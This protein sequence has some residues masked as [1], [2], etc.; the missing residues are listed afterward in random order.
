M[1][2]E[3]LFAVRA[4]GMNVWMEG[5]DQPYLDLVMGYSSVNFGHCHP[6]IIAAV[7]EAACA[8][9][10]IHAFHTAPQLE[11][12]ELLVRALATQGDYKVYFDVGGS[13]AVAAAVRLCR[14]FTRRETVVAFEGGF[15]GTGHPA[16]S[17]SDDRLLDKK[18]YGEQLSPNVIKVPFPDYLVDG[19]LR[20]ALMSLETVL[21]NKAAAAVVVEPIQG[22]AGFIVPPREFM[23]ELQ[24]L[25][26]RHGTLVI[27]DE[28]QSGIG[29]CGHFFAYQRSNI[30]SPDVVVVSKSLAG[31]YYPLSA[32]IAKNEL[33]STVPSIGTAFQSTF[34]NNPFGTTIA[35]RTLEFALREHLFD[36]AKDHGAELLRELRSLLCPALTRLRGVGLALA[37]DISDSGRPAPEWAKLFVACALEERVLVYRSGVYRNVIKIAPPLTLDGND[38]ETIITRLR[39]VITRFKKVCIA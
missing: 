12:S 23:Q 32:V 13:N 26:R 39:A 19:S 16:A 7:H 31:G 1:Y 35:L 30:E 15:H 36:K 4:E 3:S 27:I 37:F 25:A 22:A 24:C 17:L 20:A 18:Q 38:V 8:L 11:L 5:D 9:D 14:T 10:Q 29:R 28:I 2:P 21:V 33:F 6:V 34:N